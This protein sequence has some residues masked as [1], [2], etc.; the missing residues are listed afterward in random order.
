MN[1]NRIVS[2]FSSSFLSYQSERPY[3][4]YRKRHE[5][6]KLDVNGQLILSRLTLLSCLSLFTSYPCL[7]ICFRFPQPL[8]SCTLPQLQTQLYR[9]RNALAT[10]DDLFYHHRLNIILTMIEISC[11]SDQDQ[12]N[13]VCV[14]KYFSNRS[15]EYNGSQPNV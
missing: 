2:K 13:I 15:I 11:L 4:Y 12:A 5:D 9:G 1:I 6:V 7:V 8:H 3:L 14:S 10:T